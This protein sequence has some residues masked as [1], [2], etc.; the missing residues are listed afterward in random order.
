MADQ[1]SD[2]DRVKGATAILAACIA[3]ALHETDTSFRPRLVAQIDRA[4]G[5]VRDDPDLLDHHDPEVLL[6]AR[7]L[8]SGFSRVTGQGKPFLDC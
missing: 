7:E 1:P 8:L 5:M 6:W 3:Q 2:L 4:Y